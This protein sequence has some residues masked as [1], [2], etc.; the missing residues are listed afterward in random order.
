MLG[1][2]LTDA[3][4]AARLKTRD[5]TV[6]SRIDEHPD[7]KLAGSYLVE[8]DGKVLQAGLTQDQAILYLGRLKK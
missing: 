1:P 6:I 4:E 2:E 5:E 7:T 8:R 3:I